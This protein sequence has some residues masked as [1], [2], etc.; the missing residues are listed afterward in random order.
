MNKLVRYSK[1]KY[2]LHNFGSILFLILL[3]IFSWI[4]LEGYKRAFVI[5]PISLGAFI[6]FFRSRNYLLGIDIYDN[7]VSVKFIN[8]FF[9]TKVIVFS[10]EELNPLYISETNKWIGSLDRLYLSQKNK[11]LNF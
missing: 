11:I 2:I 7:H 6:H 8:Q 3:F 5:L 1:L 4:L 9:F 10:P